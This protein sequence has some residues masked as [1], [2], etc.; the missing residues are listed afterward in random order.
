M[1]YGAHQAEELRQL[2]QRL[3]VKVDADPDDDA[4]YLYF[5]HGSSTA[6]WGNRTA[7]DPNLPERETDFG[8]GFYTFQDSYNG[9]RSAEDRA[10]RKA[11]IGGVAFILRVRISNSDYSQLSKLDF[12]SSSDADYEGAV[13]SYRGGREFS[14]YQ[15]VFG[16][17]AKI[18]SGKWVKNFAYPNQ[19]KFEGTGIARLQFD[20]IIPVLGI[21]H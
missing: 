1:L 6:S 3:G 13:A 5:D 7:I 19:Y 9:R 12:R 10:L 16:P 21:S 11:K 2:A 18:H 20:A 15:L 8:K 17:V 4:S 14:G